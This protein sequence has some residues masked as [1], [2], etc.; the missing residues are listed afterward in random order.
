MT[1]KS[2]LNRLGTLQSEE[3]GNQLIRKL[4]QNLS[5]KECFS[6]CEKRGNFS[7]PFNPSTRFKRNREMYLKDIANS[8]GLARLKKQLRFSFFKTVF[9][10]YES[11]VFLLLVNI[12]TFFALFGDY[13]RIILLPPS[14]DVVFDILVILIIVIFIL[15]ISVYLL[16]EQNYF[17]GFYF[18]LDITTTVFLIFDLTFVANLFF[19]PQTTNSN[20]GTAIL[21][22]LSKIF[23]IIRI[24]RVL[25]LFKTQEQQGVKIFQSRQANDKAVI[26]DSK[27]KK[28]LKSQNI[29]RIIILI[30]VMLIT[31]PL[32]NEDIYISK[33]KKQIDNIMEY[34]VPFLYKYRDKQEHLLQVIKEKW[35]S[36]KL[37]LIELNISGLIQFKE[38]E[39]LRKMDVIKGEIDMVYKGQ[40]FRGRMS[41]SRRYANKV[42]ALLDL[43]NMLFVCLTLML[44]IF[45]INKDFS[46]LIL[47][48]LERMIARI[49]LVSMNP[50]LALK[51]RYNE[52]GTTQMNETLQIEQAII[53]ISELLILG[54]GQAGCQIIS[55]FMID[56]DQD[57]DQIIP[58]QKIYAIY[59]FC[60]IRKFTDTTEILLEEVMVFVNTLAEI[61]HSC[62]DKYGGAANKNIGDAFL[63]VWKLIQDKSQFTEGK[64]SLD[65][66]KDKDFKK[67]V[68]D[69]FNRQLAELSLLCFIDIIIQCETRQHIL[70]YRKHP[71]LQRIK[72]YSVKMGFGLHVG[73]SIE[74]AI[75]SSYKIDASYLSPNVNM[76]SKLE[77][78]TKQFGKMILFTGQLYDMFLSP[79][80]K[81]CCRH[82]DTVKFKGSLFPYRL[83]TVDLFIHNLR[84]EK[85]FPRNDSLN[86][87]SIQVN[88]RET[89]QSK[90]GMISKKI[91][92]IEESNQHFNNLRIKKLQTI[93]EDE[94]IQKKVFSDN[95][96]RIFNQE[97]KR[98]KEFKVIYGFGLDAYL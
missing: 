52:N 3:N 66:S 45:F 59:G 53:K 84:P 64:L 57:F 49:K 54:F 33:H 14:A 89:L 16:S 43:I 60:D 68:K 58:G 55:Q 2:F 72:N 17:L 88:I 73:W 80:L 5:Q 42:Q 23:R 32:F 51:N 97:D 56:P 8:S 81:K 96:Q 12:C 30:M 83:Y 22:E 21:I 70:E 25:K 67:I 28:R 61:V 91:K 63:L 90:F 92:T 85:N 69:P 24:I 71:K 36:Y 50:L 11:F 35:D 76:S 98:F 26:K 86:I 6:T 77:G 7:G 47:N 79:E 93:E 29:K 48:P 94:F 15:E 46:Q 41:Y 38:N 95:F 39:S 87:Q 65:P 44:S 27:I 78:A 19:Y 34:Q 13:F 62:T 75:G 9:S 31:I 74:G 20:A 4:T 10:V 40:I 18:L 37:K 82:L 1:H